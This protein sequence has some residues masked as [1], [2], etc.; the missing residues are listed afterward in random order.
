MPDWSVLEVAKGLLLFVATK[1]V[2]DA[3]VRYRRGYAAIR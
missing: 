1:V 3:V 2:V